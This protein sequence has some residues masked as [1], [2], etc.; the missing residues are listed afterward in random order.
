M[1]GDRPS[2]VPD[3]IIA[4]IRSRERN[5]FVEL[6]KNKLKPGDRVQI[7]SGLLEGKR[8]RY[9]GEASH[10]HVRVLLQL[11]GSERQVRLSSDAVE[12]I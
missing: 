4:E 10:R 2:H 1:S 7:I 3:Q 12:Q 6:P 8:G 11:L 5:G 9:D